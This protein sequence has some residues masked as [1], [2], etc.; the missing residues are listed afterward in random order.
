MT[1]PTLDDEYILTPDGMGPCE[2]CGAV[3]PFNYAFASDGEIV[4]CY[5]QDPAGH[6]PNCPFGE[7]TR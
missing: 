3:L 7:E 5:S 1:G 6:G 4:L 2:Y